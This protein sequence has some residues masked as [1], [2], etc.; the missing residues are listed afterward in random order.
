MKI[1]IKKLIPNNWIVENVNKDQIKVYYINE[2]R[3]SSPKPFV[4]PKVVDVN[5]EFMEAIAM[6]IGDGSMNQTDDKHLGFASID[7]DMVK[8][9]FDFF[10]LQFKIPLKDFT[11]SIR[12][13]EFDKKSLT[14]LSKALKI[15]KRK[16]K[17][18]LTTRTKNPAC[19]LQISGKIFR[20]LFGSL[21]EEIMSSNFFLN[22][23][24]RRA[25][26]RGLF[27]AEGGLGIVKKEN[28]IAYIAFHLS[29]YKEE[30]L[31]NFVQKLLGLEGITSKHF[32]RKNKGER[33]IQI[34]NWK[35]YSK[36]WQMDLFALN[37]RKEY[38]FLKKLSVTKFCCKINPKLKD[39]LLEEKYLSGRQIASLIGTSSTTFYKIKNNKR[40]FIDISCLINLSM[41]SRIP[42]DKIK[43][44]V[45]EFR[46]NTTTPIKDKQ[47]ID[48]I[49]DLK[50][51]L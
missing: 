49:F 12:C 22:K 6:Y 27:A 16:F 28:Y 23:D 9:M 11:F 37:K 21:I 24:L 18:K 10:T 13:K 47:F 1:D 38:K 51:F 32:I 42:L 2:G 31:A 35:N 8:F 26:L 5:K 34:T 39:S 40:D 15:P 14:L 25:F 3:G 19:H 4:L 17:V 50:T 30:K 33:Y 46:V 41:L 43:T 7:Y 36:L 48:F 44:N 45:I 20:L 29:Y